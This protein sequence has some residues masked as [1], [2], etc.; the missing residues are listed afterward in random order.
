MKTKKTRQTKTK[1]MRGIYKLGEDSN[2][3]THT[4]THT[5]AY[6]HMQKKNTYTHIHTQTHTRKPNHRERGREKKKEKNTDKC[7]G[8]PVYRVIAGGSQ[9]RIRRIIVQ[10]VKHIVR[11]H[12]KVLHH[13]HL[14]RGERK[15][16]KKTSYT[17]ITMRFREPYSNSKWGE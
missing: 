7:D 6:T 15:R 12:Q 3:H 2:T 1:T 5:H 14:Q 13:T 16:R 11:L 4:H 8:K 10:V 17:V 9:N